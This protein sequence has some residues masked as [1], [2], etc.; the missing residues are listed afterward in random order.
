MLE[1][2][3]ALSTDMLCHAAEI[4]QQDATSHRTL[5]SISGLIS[6]TSD[7]AARLSDVLSAESQNFSWINAFWSEKLDFLCRG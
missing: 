5:I 6:S 7:S 2:C 1:D 4:W 3:T